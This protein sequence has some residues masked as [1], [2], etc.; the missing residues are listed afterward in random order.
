MADL[1]ECVLQIKGLRE[2]T[3]R[4]SDLVKRAEPSR[5]GLTPRDRTIPPVADLLRRLADGEADHGAWLR[6][7]LGVPAPYES[8]HD[9][10]MFDGFDVFGLY[11]RFLRRRGQN[12]ELLDRC[13]AADLSRT[14]AHPVR[15][16]MTVADM[17]ALML[18]ADFDSLAEIRGA[19]GL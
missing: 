16:T 9:D 5:L 15:G 3:D 7:T 11:T 14:G 19:F 10:G 4:L 18:A 13:S 8:F 2:T 1:L 6:S 17:V 12:L